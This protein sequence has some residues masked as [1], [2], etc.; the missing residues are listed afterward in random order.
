MCTAPDTRDARVRFALEQQFY[1]PGDAVTWSCPARHRPSQPDIRCTRR[2]SQSVWSGIA[3]CIVIPRI[4]PGAL[5]VSPTTIKLRWTCEPPESCQGSWKIRAQCRLDGPR[6]G[7]C[8][9]QG[10]TREQPLQGRDGTVTCSSL[11][12]FTSYRVTISGGFPATRPPSTVLY[13]QRVTTSEAAPD[14]PEIEPLD[15]STKTLRWKPLPPCKGAIVGYQL[16]IT[17]RREYDSDFLEVE[18]LRVNQSVTKY[19]LQ[20]WRY[21]TNYTVTIQGLTAAGLGQA[22]RWDFDTNLFDTCRRQGPWTTNVTFPSEQM[23]FQVNDTVLVTCA[24]D[25][26]SGPFPANCTELKDRGAVWDISGV[27][28]LRMCN[29]WMRHVDFD[30]AQTEFGV[31]AK[32]RVTCH[33]E[34][35]QDSFSV[36]CREM[37]SGRFEWDSGAHTCVR[38]CKIPRTWDSRLQ[39]APK[40]QFYAPGELVTLS[41]REGYRPSPPMIVCA[42]N[43]SQPVWSDT[44]TCQQGEAQTPQPGGLAV[45]VAV[46]VVLVLLGAG[47]LLRWFVLAR[48]HQAEA[49]RPAKDAGEALYTELQPWDT[50][51]IYCT[52]QTP[53]HGAAGRN[54]TASGWHAAP[55]APL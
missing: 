34:F 4:I 7:P 26:E 33:Q 38:K 39:F 43:G 2:G 30:P 53:E 32:G 20:P 6:L 11:H 47:A 14:Q 31:G 5:E 49:S 48:K 51:D 21:G 41:C 3:A 55:R 8:R 9:R 29:D 45:A 23:V 1:S 42:R 37:E 40:R 25:P 36:T 44:P 19:L 27:K 22:S 46:P 10:L 54:G 17:A 18:E 12:P 52:I 16:N 24:A 15:P 13:T 35:Q 50:P 28:C